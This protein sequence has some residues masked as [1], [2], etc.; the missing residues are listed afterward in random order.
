MVFISA[1][2]IVISR[3][4]YYLS[5]YIQLFLQY[6]LGFHFP[7]FMS[8]VYPLSVIISC[9]YKIVNVNSF[10]LYPLAVQLHNNP[11]RILIRGLSFTKSSHVF[12]FCKILST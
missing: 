10:T 5:Q 6:L 11:T 8:F 4:S 9:P 7:Q 3:F 12:Y 1:S 2:Y